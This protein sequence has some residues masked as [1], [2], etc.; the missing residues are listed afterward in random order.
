MSGQVD[1]F[2]A[3]L[4]QSL[5]HI[6]SGRVVALGVGSAS[7]HEM[8]PEVPPVAAT[9]PGFTSTVWYGMVAPPKTPAPIVEKLSGRVVDI[10]KQS[11]IVAKLQSVGGKA[12][13]APAASFGKSSRTTSSTGKRSFEMQTSRR[14]D[15]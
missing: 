11:T 8:L 13:G 15:V 7:K 4:S 14:R 2:F 5:P 10:M 12:I 3:E 6:K 1:L 9:L